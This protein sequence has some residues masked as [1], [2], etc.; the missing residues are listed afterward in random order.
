MQDLILSGTATLS[1][2]ICTRDDIMLYLISQNMDASMSFK[3]MESVRKGK[4]A[5][6]AEGNWPAWKESM[7]EHGVPDWYIGSCEKIMYM[8]PKAH[9]AAYVMMAWRVAWCKIHHPIEYYTAYFSIRADGF[10]YEKMC[11]GHDHFVRVIEDLRRRS[12]MLTDVEKLTLRDMRVVEEMFARGFDFVPIDIYTA[13]AD[14][15]QIIRGKIMP[16]FQSIAGMGEK[17]AK[18]LEEAAAEGK[19]LSRED[20]IQR[21]KISQTMAET[22]AALGLLGDLPLSNQMSLLDIMMETAGSTED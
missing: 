14:R 16:S 6:G 2:A 20:M 5:K 10:D 9:A 4:V 3:I 8:F 17:A 18:S 21:A 13:K 22:M 15:F 7:E 11:T 1:E 19:F 12:D